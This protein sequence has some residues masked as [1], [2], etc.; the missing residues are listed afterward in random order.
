MLRGTLPLFHD[1]FV[2]QRISLHLPQGEP[3]HLRIDPTLMQQV[4]VNLLCN[5][6]EAVALNPDTRPPSIAIRQRI[7]A[8]RVTISIHD[9]G[10]GMTEAQRAHLFVPFHTSK[11]EGLG[12]GLV[13]CKRI[14]ESYGGTIWAEAVPQGAVIAFSLPLQPQEEG[15]QE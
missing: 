1:Q 14:I 4:L 13:I 2:R 9:N 5:A 10:T 3:V 7:E 15:E 6:S 12:L 8:N 11:K